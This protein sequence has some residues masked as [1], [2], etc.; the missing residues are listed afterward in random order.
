MSHSHRKTILHLSDLHFGRLQENLVDKLLEFI[1]SPDHDQVDLV[2]ISGD[3]TQRARSKQFIAA[4][5]FLKKVGL[6]VL[7]VPGN[8]DVP[9]YNLLKR[10]FKPF[11]NYEAHISPIA[12]HFYEDRDIFVHGI[13]TNNIFSIAEGR[14]ST[15]EVELLE[16]RFH[17]AEANN[18]FKILVCHHPIFEKLAVSSTKT[19]N[20]LERILKLKPHLI[21]FGHNHQ[22][23]SV[24]L[25]ERDLEPPVLIGA[26]TS[27]SSRLRAE[28]N[29]I[30]LITWDPINLVTAVKV[31]VYEVD[32]NCFQ[33]ASEKRFQ[34]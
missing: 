5:E 13:K 26:G 28:A 32:K 27:T 7:A 11:K 16:K 19:K 3:L 17:A 4:A 20:L 21:L 30:N 29:S 34:F 8:H 15:T 12:A 23:N 2:V 24:W 33:Q 6:P 31:F 22:S 1:H 25:N 18:K 9:L 10:F 14:V